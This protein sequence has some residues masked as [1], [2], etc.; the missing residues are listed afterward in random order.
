MPVDGGNGDAEVF[1]VG[2]GELGDVVGNLAG[3]IGADLAMT[4]REEVRQRRRDGVAGGWGRR[5]H[6]RR[7]RGGWAKVSPSVIASEATGQART[8]VLR[9]IARS[10]ATK[11]SSA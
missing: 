5:G 2:P 9:V 7:L 8:V 1:S 6:A 10:E 4:L 11:Q 3:A